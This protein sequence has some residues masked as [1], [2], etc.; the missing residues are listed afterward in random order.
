MKEDILK[1]EENI[2]SPFTETNK[3]IRSK[4]SLEQSMK[5]LKIDDNNNNK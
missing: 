4:K 2:D 1:S 3:D 5:S